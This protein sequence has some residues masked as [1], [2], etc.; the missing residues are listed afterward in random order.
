LVTQLRKA[1]H[2]LAPGRSASAW[3]SYDEDNTYSPDARARKDA[4]VE[5]IL[6]ASRPGVVWDMGCNTGRYALLAARHAGHVVA[7]DGDPDAVDMLYRRARASAPNVLPLVVNL[8]DPSPDRGWAQAERRGLLQ[9]GPADVALC[10]ALV[11]HLSIGGNVPLPRVAAWLRRTA[12]SAIVEFVPKD[13]PGAQKLLRWKKDVYPGYTQV[14]FEAALRE[15][16]QISDQCRLPDSG[17]ILYSLTQ[18]AS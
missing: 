12:R 8:L 6:A 11:H 13:D 5:G 16:F 4:F 15:H 1:V 17:R 18:S 14:A 10:L 3:T 9:R 7:M 2:G